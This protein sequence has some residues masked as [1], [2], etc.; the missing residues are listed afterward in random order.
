MRSGRERRIER[1][2]QRLLRK[3]MPRVIV[4]LILS[5]TAMSAFLTSFAL[6]RLAVLR[7]WVRYPVA[8]VVAYLVFLLLL[9]I[10][11]WLR[12]RV[13]EPDVDALELIHTDLGPSHH[14]EGF[15]GAGDFGGAGIGGNWTS[16]VASSSESGIS[17]GG[18]AVAD[19]ISG[20]DLDEGC[21]PV[22][23]IILAAVAI[24]AGVIASF[25]VIYIAPALLAEILLDGVLVAGLYR[26]VRRIEHRH[27]LQSA[28]RRTIVP[29]SL[30]LVF[31]TVAGYLLQW[32]IPDAHT[33][34]EVWSHITGVIA[35]YL[36]ERK[37]F[38][39]FKQFS[40]GK[41]RSNGGNPR[42][43]R[44]SSVEQS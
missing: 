4:T 8:I 43:S 2:K 35:Q 10:W 23:A 36:Q 19:G 25:Y 29:A 26:R 1:I 37:S 41:M 28:V 11:L 39:S 21:L 32:A 16:S 33:I 40:L 5:M 9:A 14:H 20:L 6:L 30:V 13:P 42:N 34:G 15:G 3:S 27:W 44:C 18:S 22:V 17:G 24:F 31:F 12:R 38:T 7:M